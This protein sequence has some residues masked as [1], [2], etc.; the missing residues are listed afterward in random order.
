MDGFKLLEHINFELNL[1]VISELAGP[2]QTAPPSVASTASELTV[3]GSRG[4]PEW[5]FGGFLTRVMESPA[6]IRHGRAATA[7]VDLELLPYF[8]VW[9]A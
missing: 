4:R 8:H 9:R 2:S 7:K 5:R 6:C 1:P 3:A